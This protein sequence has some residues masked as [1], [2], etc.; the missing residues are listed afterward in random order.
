[1]TARP[2]RCVLAAVL[3]VILAVFGGRCSATPFFAR[4]LNMACSAC[5]NG[6]PRLNAFGFAFRAN[7]FRLP[8][9]S[10]STPL[11]WKKTVPLAV[12]VKP[13]WTQ[14]QPGSFKVQFTETQLLGGGLVGPRT[15]LY[16]HHGWYLDAKPQPFPTWEFWVQQVLDERSGLML[17]AGQFELPLAYSPEISKTTIAYP[18]IL[19]SSGLVSNDVA[20]GGAVSG[21]QLSGRAG[22]RVSWF[23]EAGAPA[24]NQSGN[25]VG[26]RTF[27]GR[28]RDVFGRVEAGA[29]GRSGGAFLYLTSPEPR[30]PGGAGGGHG[31]RLGLDGTF[32]WK[33]NQVQAMW[34]YGENAR[35]AGKGTVRGGFVEADRMFLPWLGATIRLDVQS[36]SLP[37]PAHYLDAKT[38]TV[39][40]YPV[41]RVKLAAEVQ[42]LD[43]G[44]AALGFQAALTY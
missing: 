1:M 37:G 33:A 30:T 23:L 4:Q 3:V 31:T 42:A 21:I 10:A 8:G 5:H 6:F 41:P 44:G 38:L 9:D 27:F 35:P 18:V 34:V 17:K 2:N 36:S 13:T 19:F 29:P 7:N 16:L 24:F 22:R 32:T 20:L 26:D 43:H 39:R 40:F 25:P 14:F 11:I 28:F 12:Q 15:S